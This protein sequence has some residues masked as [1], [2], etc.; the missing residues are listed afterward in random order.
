MFKRLPVDRAAL[1]E[2]ARGLR[3]LDLAVKNVQLVNVLTCEVYPADIG[4][5]AGRIAV[6]GPAGEY[7]LQARRTS[8]KLL[9]DPAR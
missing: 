4:V 9:L 7:D 5:Y 6:V 3:P 8:G 1:V 2:A